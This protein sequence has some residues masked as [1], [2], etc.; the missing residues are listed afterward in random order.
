M[1]SMTKAASKAKNQRLV[2]V[3]GSAM[4][5][6]G[7]HALPGLTNAAGEPTNAI[8]G[9]TMILLKA[10]EELK[11]RYVVVTWDKSD[12]TVFRKKLYPE[13]KAQRK[14][15]PDDLKA[16]V[17]PTREVVEAL[18]LPWVELGGYEADDIIGTFA[19]QAEVL[20]PDLEVIIVTGDMD[21]LQLI[22][23]RT[24]VY[25]MK[26]GFSDTVI[27]DMAAM[28]E[29]Y[30]LTPQQFI[31]L[32]A[33]KGDS[34]DNIPGVPGVGEKTAQTLIQTY[35]TLDGVYQHV[36]ELKGK[37]KERMVENKELAYLSRELSVIVRDAPIKLDLDAAVV[38]RYDRDRIKELFHRYEFKS[39]LR[40]LPEEAAPDAEPTL[41]DGI[42]GEAPPVQAATK[43]ERGHLKSAHYHTVTNQQQLQELAALLGQQ[44]AFAL[45]TETDG[46]ASATCGLVGISVSCKEGEA[47]YIP[48]THEAGEQLSLEAVQTALAP[49]FSDP[50]IGKVGHNI[51]FDYEVL[52]RHGLTPTPITFDTMIAGFLMNPAGRAQSLSD[53][54]FSEFDID[55]IPISELIGSGR[56]Q[57]SF[58]AAPIE[59]AT[60][61]AAEDADVTWR[62]YLRTKQQLEEAGFTKLAERT[63]WPLIE[64]LGKMELAG[65]LLDS[66][67]L[68]GLQQTFA[69]EIEALQKAI[70]KEAGE[71][72]NIASPSQLAVVLYDKLQLNKAGVKK[73]KTGY[74]TAAK[75]LDKIRHAHPIVPLISE[76][77]ELTKLQSTYIETLPELTDA[78]GRIHTSFSQTVAQTGRLSSNNPNLQNI[79]VR[80]ELGRK[81]RDAFV[82]PPGRKLVSADYSQIE[83]RV[84]AAL[85][86]DQGM[87]ET[88]KQGI[89][90]HQQ[91]A[92]EMFGVKLEEV[93]KEQRYAAKT[94]NFG[95]LY[96]MSAHGLS[97][98]TGMSREDAASFIERYFAVR[99]PLAD[100]IERT[101]EFGREHGYTETKLGR[102]RP[103][104]DITASNFTVRAA[105]E[106]VAVN[107]PI[108]G[109]A[110]DIYK[111]AMIELAAQLPAGA[112]L[113]LQI[114]DELIVECRSEQADEVSALMKRVMESVYDLGVPLAV[115]TAVGD[116]WGQL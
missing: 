61:Y 115:D 89:D 25:T 19:S 30:G 110:A 47:Y 35:K 75:E 66:S 68:A 65:V 53:M 45:D 83:L 48:L 26:R 22:S 12:E 31:D 20:R 23:D 60:T 36:D 1:K 92:A 17:A 11:P 81:I 97:I 44:T 57:T 70:W 112:D 93:T 116:N 64:I 16:Q 69:K 28:Q 32:K 14:K 3:D 34:S 87:I 2:L 106:R 101:K 71:E 113:L 10:L 39:L 59:E 80:T 9:F 56:N 5:H 41:F 46:I 108:Q 84:A 49:V 78:N 88:F 100:Y 72:F 43:P 24:K 98:A 94:I 37:L 63:E 7:Y 104:P 77:R 55:M 51:K 111:L 67:V 27:Y 91:T 33:L 52:A 114:H 8:Y 79:P 90:L 38:G 76:Y 73:G 6:R 95:V 109:T 103:C 42:A 15:S 82:A 18:G 102:R 4:F 21:E 107:V 13:Y 40:K 85:S 29:K 58:A 99:K 50:K 96:G 74:S 62:L 105:A 54:A 86:G